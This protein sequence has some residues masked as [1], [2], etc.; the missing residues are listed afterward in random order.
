MYEIISG[1]MPRQPQTARS[2]RYF[3]ISSRSR[4]GSP[5]GSLWSD[6]STSRDLG[7]RQQPA[8]SSP[9]QRQRPPT[10]SART[11][12]NAGHPTNLDSMREGRAQ[13]TH[14]DS[15]FRPAAER[16]RIPDSRDNRREESVKAVA[17]TSARHVHAHNDASQSPVAQQERAPS[18]SAE[19]PASD[20]RRYF[21]RAKQPIPPTR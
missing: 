2:R 3:K 17:P 8:R 21:P 18:P 10:M 12:H 9:D 1:S 13:L 20:I 4:A 6:L 15:S 11:R 7:P 5:H 16:A 14:D 19:P